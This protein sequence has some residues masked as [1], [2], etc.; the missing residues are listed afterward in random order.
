MH[1]KATAPKKD[2]KNKTNSAKE[3]MLEDSIKNRKGIAR[4]KLNK[5]RSAVN[6]IKLSLNK[7]FFSS[8]AAVPEKTAEINANKNHEIIFR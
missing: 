4:I 7:I 1:R 6:P 3:D 2:L 5:A 8:I